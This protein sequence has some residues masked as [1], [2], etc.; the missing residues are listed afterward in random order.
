[1]IK[2]IHN[3]RCRKSREALKILIEK[4]LNPVIIEYLKQN[5]NKIQIKEI[6][7]LLNQED[8]NKIIRKNESIY[9]ERYREKKFSD[10]ELINVIYENPILLER[11]I[12]IKGNRAIIGRPPE[13]ILDLFK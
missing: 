1:M 7:S 12:V 5:L 10:T 11:P 3:P 13:K 4:K 8:L 9:K 2:I 6:I